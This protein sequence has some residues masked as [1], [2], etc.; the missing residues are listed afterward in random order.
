[1]KGIAISTLAFFLITIVSISLLVLYVGLQLS[2]MLRKA[3]CSFVMGLTSFLPL[4]EHLKPSIPAFCKVEPEGIKTVII[5]SGDP[6]YIS[7]RIAAYVLACWEVTG[8]VNLG[9]DRNCYEIVLK[10]LQ[11]PISEDDV[12]DNLPSGYE[13]VMDWKAEIT[14][15]KSIG[16]YY[17][18]TN[19]K[20]M[21][22]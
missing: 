7:R 15:P 20:I 5:E 11:S 10:N 8:K 19:S 18:S 6:D 14:Q 21:V 12:K 17:N 22:M 3:Y 2:P 16:I 4:P 1:M 9:Q 13:D